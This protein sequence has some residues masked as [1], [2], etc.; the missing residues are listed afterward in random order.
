M[1]LQSAYEQLEEAQKEAT[2]MTATLP[3]LNAEDD[4]DKEQENVILVL[5]PMPLLEVPSPPPAGTENAK[6]NTKDPQ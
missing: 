4:L 3:P 5:Q 6:K 2:K 1:I